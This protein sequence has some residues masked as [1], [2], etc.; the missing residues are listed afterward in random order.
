[1]VH[2]NEAGAP[3]TVADKHVSTGR[4]P[5]STHDESPGAAKRELAE[6]WRVITASV[7]GMGTGVNVICVLTMGVFAPYLA[8]T[9]GWSFQDIMIGMMMLSVGTLIGGPIAG[10]LADKYGTRPVALI[11][12]VLF[13]LS[14]ATFAFNP[15]RIEF[16][17]ATWLACATLG[18]GTGP[19]LYSR[20]VNSWF[21]A[22]KG[23]ALG[24]ATMG[25]L[26]GPAERAIAAW[27]I[28]EGDLR[29]AYLALAALPLLIGLPFCLW[30]LRERPVATVGGVKPAAPGLTAREALGSWRFWAI[31]APLTVAFFAIGGPVPHLENLLASKDYALA[32]RVNMVSTYAIAALLARPVIG[33]LFDRFWAPAVICAGM[34]MASFTGWVL[35]QETVSYVGGVVAIAALGS[36][37]AVM[38]TAPPYLVARYFGMRSFGAIC[39][40]VL[41]IC[42]VI[43]AFGPIFFGRTFD[44]TGSYDSMLILTTAAPLCLLIMLSLGRYPAFGRADDPASAA[45]HQQAATPARTGAG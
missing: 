40:L 26:L 14:F 4:K 13:A 17:W 45:E 10:A 29:A 25:P 3:E 33:W 5:V 43:G 2:A 15:G 27:F 39:G 42:S 9:H 24:L 30:G 22:S 23:L 38:L 34:F 28:A 31:V 18:V 12:Q 7:L 6:G 11:S 37:T 41:G 19:L 21:N 16:F 1:M 20:A 36:T 35:A 44:Q 32:D 8:K